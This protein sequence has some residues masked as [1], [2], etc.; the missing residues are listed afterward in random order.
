MRCG[1]QRAALALRSGATVPIDAS[2]E[3]PLR[4]HVRPQLL[5]AQIDDLSIPS[6]GGE[7]GASGE[8]AGAGLG[9]W[10]WIGKGA[11]DGTHLAP[12]IA[13][14]L[15][16][17]RRGRH[18]EAA[19]LGVERSGRTAAARVREAREERFRV[20]ERRVE[21]RKLRPPHC[22]RLACGDMRV[23]VVKV[24]RIER[25]EAHRMRGRGRRGGGPCSAHERGVVASRS[26]LCRGGGVEPLAPEFRHFRQLTLG[27]QFVAAGPTGDPTKSWFPRRK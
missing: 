6:R 17:E 15:V 11:P 25:D 3:A 21:P 12:R 20:G 5:V 24:L 9:R 23:A 10:R 22:P 8:E 4:S 1:L 16:G 7:G 18:E 13:G 27:Y 26:E 2:R 14:R 19:L